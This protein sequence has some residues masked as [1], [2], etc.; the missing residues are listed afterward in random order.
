M[1]P[2]DTSSDIVGPVPNDGIGHCVYDQGDHQGEENHRRGN[3]QN[4]AVEEQQE[5]FEPVVLDPLS[6]PAKPEG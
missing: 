2:A 4:L 5:V 1:P 3:A 6:R